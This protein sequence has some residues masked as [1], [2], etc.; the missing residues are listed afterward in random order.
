MVWLTHGLSSL[1][2]MSPTF[3]IAWF[4]RFSITLTWHVLGGLSTLPCPLDLSVPGAKK[5]SHPGVSAPDQILETENLDQFG[6][7]ASPWSAQL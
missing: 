2:V 7:A 3:S 6:S 5:K 1:T 4:H